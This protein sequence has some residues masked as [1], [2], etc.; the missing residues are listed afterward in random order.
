MIY[1]VIIVGA[2]PAGATAALYAERLG[3][4]TLLLDRAKFPRDKICG[5]ALGGKSVA[6]LRELGLLDRVRR[7]PGAK[8]DTIVFGSP[9]HTEARIDLTRAQRRDFVTGFVVRRRIFD[10][11]LFEEARSRATACHE[12]FAVENL[13]VDRG[14][15]CG[16][17]GRSAD[18][19][20]REFAGRIVLGA[21]GYRSVV[22]RKLGLY[23]IDAGHWIVALRQYMRNVAGLGDQIELH[24]VDGVL[25]GY[26]WIFP[27]ENGC[28]NVGIGMVQAAMKAQGVHLPD[29]L[30]RAIRSPHFAARFAGAEALEKPVGWHLPVGSKRRPCHGAGYMLLGD[31]AGLI[32]PFTGEGIANA[33]YSARRA[34]ETARLA[35]NENDFGAASLSR[36]ATRL[37]AE[38]GDELKV[39]TRLQKL[40]RN[41]TLLNFTIRKAA[42]NPKVR[43]VICA[44]IAEEI[45]RKQLTNPLFYLKL[46]FA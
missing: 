46:L 36:Y 26:F 31:A 1:D 41:R 42:R 28:A 19:E 14:A 10:A 7:L 23:R 3:L 4:S 30:S 43:D 44:M 8:V 38:I 33:M 34:A 25:P 18:G 13:I 16:V 20:T 17:R 27:L 9:D 32:D 24:Y 22:A 5:D 11:F 37:W 12:N 40:G 35:C 6:I 15:V 2:G 29:E 45:P 39:S 21:D